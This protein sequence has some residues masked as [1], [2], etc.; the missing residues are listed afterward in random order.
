MSPTSEVKLS[1]FSSGL[2][3]KFCQAIFKAGGT[4]AEANAIAENGSLMMALIQAHRLGVDVVSVPSRGICQSV[5]SKPG[6]Y[7]V[8]V[9][10]GN[11]IEQMVMAG[12]YDWHNDDINSG[13]FQVNG[14]GVVTTTLE[15][16][17]LGRKASAR[18]A[19]THMEANDLRPGE[20]E[21]LLAFG[22]TYPEMQR[23]FPIICLGSSWVNRH[24]SRRAP[25]L[26]GYDSRRRLNL[27]WYGSGWGERC[28]FLA[29]RK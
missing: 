9:D 14:T 2:A 4:P 20:I 15:L 19:L 21:E 22:A 1:D 13:N 5:N 12:R 16:V 6:E 8:T 23:Q 7:T 10:Y 11:T 27:D 18:Q 25:Y 17:H 24:G 28:R 29:V 26:D 3:H